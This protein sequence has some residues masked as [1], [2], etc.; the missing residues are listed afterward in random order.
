MTTETKELI[1]EARIPLPDDYMEE[2]EVAATVKAAAD[3]FRQ[4]LTEAL[5][6]GG[7]TVVVTRA[8]PTPPKKTRQPRSDV[9][10][11]RAPRASA[12]TNG[13]AENPIA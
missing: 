9:G 3:S 7:F 4:G 1:I 10:S 11:T 2:V 13:A 8:M 5:P 6:D 12:A